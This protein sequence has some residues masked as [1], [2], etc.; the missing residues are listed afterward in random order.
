MIMQSATLN[1]S[2]YCVYKSSIPYTLFC[3]ASISLHILQNG[4]RNR[5]EVYSIPP[6]L[7]LALN[8]NK[9]SLDLRS[10]ELLVISRL[11]FAAAQG[12]H[13]IR[14]QHKVPKSDWLRFENQS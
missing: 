8:L 6:Q 1:D 12:F 7:I 14:L 10:S 5:A 11:S 2:E 4:G 13:R 3:C 9:S